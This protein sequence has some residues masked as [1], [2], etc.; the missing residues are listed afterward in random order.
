MAKIYR[1]A[2]ELGITT[3]LDVS[4]P[5]PDS[6]SGK[7]DWNTVLKKTLPYVDIFLP[8]AEEL[9]YM[10]DREKFFQLLESSSEDK[11]LLDQFEGEDFTWMSNKILNYGAKII[12]IKCGHR[13][14]YVRTADKRRISQTGSAV[15]SDLN[16]WSDRELLE[17]S[18]YVPDI[19]SATGAGDSAVAGFLAAYIRG[20]TIERTLKYACTVGAQNVRVLDA[21]SGICSWEETTRQVD[22]NR[23]KNRLDIK[24][25]IW[26]FDHE[27]KVWIGPNDR[28]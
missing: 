27:G 15:P 14:F 24:S 16:N 21:V 20:E 19:A 7:V 25:S 2:K 17:P 6:P 9:L 3:S 1:K 23:E 13:G 26:K 12:A 18:Y 22:E 10:L 11:G 28:R 5:D 4:L 8:S